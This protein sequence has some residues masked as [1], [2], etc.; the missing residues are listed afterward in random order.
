MPLI[1]KVIY[2][3]LCLQAT[4]HCPQT[5]VAGVRKI[6]FI[7][8]KGN[9][10]LLFARYIKFGNTTFK[11]FTLHLSIHEIRSDYR[12]G[13]ALWSFNGSVDGHNFDID[14]LVPIKSTENALGITFGVQFD[15][16]WELFDIPTTDTDVSDNFPLIE[17]G[18]IDFDLKFKLK[19]RDDPGLS[20]DFLQSC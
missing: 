19:W 8:I 12:V 2:N 3:S 4:N 15:H 6:L 18:R 9:Q 11:P 14:D 10:I 16:H 7:P 13:P 5:S 17:S 1:E 20:K